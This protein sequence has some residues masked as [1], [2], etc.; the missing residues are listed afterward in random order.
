[1]DTLVRECVR[2]CKLD[3]TLPE[4]SWN[5]LFRVRS[6]DYKGDE[7][8]VARNFTWAN[9]APALPREVGNVPLS[10][11]CTLGS[12]HYVLHFE[13]YLRPQDEWELLRAPRV[14]VNDAD[15]GTV[16]R[17]LV[18][19]GVC[20]FIEESE[21]F[22]TPKGPLLNGLFGVTKDEFT[23]SGVEIFRLIMNL[24]PLNALC[25]PMTGDVHTL[26]TWSSM[27]PYFLQPSENLL[28]S[29]ED[30]KCFFYTMSVPDSW[31]KFLAFNKVVPQDVLPSHLQGQTVYVTSRVLPMGFLNSVSLAQHV[32]RNLA[33]W[34]RELNGVGGDQG[35][36]APEHELRKDKPI[37]QSKNAWR[38]YLDNYDLLEKVEATDMVEL[39]GTCP[40]GV[41]ALRQEYEVWGV[42]RNTKK[43]VQ[44]STRCEL[45]GATVD[46]VSGV[47]YPKEVKLAKYFHLAF[48][49]VQ[50]ERASQKQWQVACGGLVYFTMF[51]KQLLGSL[52]AVWRHIESY[53]ETGS[54]SLV[55]PSV[56]RLELVRFLALLPLARMDFRLD[57]HPMV[58][59][60]DASSSGGGAC[61]SVGLTPTGVMVSQGSLR[62]ERPE[63]VQD[64]SVLVIGLFDG[65]S[66][67]RVAL[68]VLG[69]HVLGH[70]SVEKMDIAQRVVESHFPDVIHVNY[71]REI[72][73]EMVLSWS[74]K[75]SQCSLVLLGAGPPC[76]GVSGLNCDRRGALLDERSNLFV[77]VPRVKQLLREGFP[78]CPVE[79]L[80]E[81]V[82][83]MDAKDRDTMSTHVEQQPIF[84]DA[85]NLT[86]CRRPRLYWVSWELPH[87]KGYHWSLSNGIRCLQLT[88]SQPLDQVLEPGCSKF[89]PDQAFPTFTTSRP[90]SKPGRKPA[91]I[92]QCTNDELNRWTRD[93][94]RFPPYQYR[95]CHSVLT[96]QQV[97][98]V[99]NVSERELMLGFPLHYTV[100]CTGKRERGTVA[101]QDARL[102]LLGNTWSVPV[103]ASLLGPLFHSL[104]F[105]ASMSPQQV[106]DACLPGFQETVQG[107]LVRLPLRA[108][109]RVT[110][111]Q[112]KDL[113]SK[114]G[115]LISVKGEDILLTS[116]TSQVARFHR[117]R[118]SV[119]ARLWRWRIVSGWKWRSAEHIN[120][121]ELR[122][123]LTCLKW[124]V[125]H[126][127]HAQCRLIH[128]TDSMVCLHS[129]SRGRSSSRKLRRTMSRINALLLIANIQPVWGYVHTDQNPAD[130]PSRWGR[131]VK[132]KYRNVP[133]TCA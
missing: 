82:A 92:Q 74:T 91:G 26:P 71:V 124:R 76:Q 31:Q 64:L 102:T 30:V 29:S 119:P 65:I 42:P 10:E 46:G 96:S 24:T 116:P 47:A 90:C 62:G 125:Q 112:A 79:T 93:S 101:H 97:L 34:S 123:I 28:V 106:V 48:M 41:L 2:F 36:N 5:D 45:Q 52:N 51:R 111:Q 117:L 129:L 80:M 17:G 27:H 87:D 121:L 33:A 11:V 104:G 114:L 77:H 23:D 108:G 94:H 63:N 98:R 1:M 69:V 126:Q 21:V 78:W 75:F 39:H 86:W 56:C 3:A 7:V 35:V 54:R 120:A 85:G 84:C 115:N 60:S 100:P 32:H 44:R 37:S 122:A 110:T 68:D 19:A 131:R 4:T 81:S 57:M 73:A 103:V 66:A 83:S 9:I 40:P 113:A 99:P 22:M 53:N 128:L 88:G 67:L 13:Q 50:A 95:D 18:E 16:C 43:A 15:W 61:A 72:D 58:T 49:L 8:R 55:T 25:R 12:K 6:I 132:T 105:C 109:K 118:A 130:R 20:C 59:C 14:M 89:D 127:R 133:K 38:I 107:R 70:V